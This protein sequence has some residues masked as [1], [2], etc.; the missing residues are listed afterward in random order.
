M[1]KV[2]ER[3]I[4]ELTIKYSDGSIVPYNLAAKES[5]PEK[6]KEE[7]RE[8]LTELV[9]GKHGRVFVTKTNYGNNRPTNC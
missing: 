7:L 5:L 8:V 6:S 2:T 1:A 4:V 9:K 3:K